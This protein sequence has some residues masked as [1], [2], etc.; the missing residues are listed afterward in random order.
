MSLITHPD[1]P[2]MATLSTI[3]QKVVAPAADSIDQ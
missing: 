1:A 2:Y 3:I